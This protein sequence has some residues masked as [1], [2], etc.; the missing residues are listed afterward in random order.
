MILI[1]LSNQ[2]Q[3]RS[4]IIDN[5]FCYNREQ[6][7]KIKECFVIKSEF[8]KLLDEKNKALLKPEPVQIKEPSF[9]DSSLGQGL[10]IFGVGVAGFGLGFT[11]GRVSK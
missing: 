4:E 5:K 3:A 8:E 2:N 11:V 10:L 1:S 7:E 9:W 6:A